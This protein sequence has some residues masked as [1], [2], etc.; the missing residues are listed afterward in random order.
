MED[1][2]TL[3]CTFGLFQKINLYFGVFQLD[4]WWAIL[5]KNLLLGP[6]GIPKMF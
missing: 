2:P 4:H 3:S 6:F 5:I 1:I